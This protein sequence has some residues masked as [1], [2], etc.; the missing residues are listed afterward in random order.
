MAAGEA[1]YPLSPSRL[2]L[3]EHFIERETSGYEAGRDRGR[4][5][6]RR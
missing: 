5:G 3:H 1:P 6:E 4:G 2:P